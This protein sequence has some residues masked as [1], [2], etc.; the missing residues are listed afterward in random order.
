MSYISETLS[1]PVKYDCDV[2]VAGGGVA[3]VAAALAAARKGASVILLERGFMLGGLATAGIVTI[4]LPIC[5][6]MGNQVTFGLADELLRLSIEYGAEDRYPEAWLNGGS[7]EERRDGKRFEVQFNAQLFAI[8]CER[9]LR[10]AGVRILY[11]ALAVGTSVSEGRITHILIEGKSGREAIEVHRSVVD[12][13]GD[14]DICKLAGAGCVQ[15]GQGNVLAAW[16]YSFG[17]GSFD[18]NMC[19]FCDVPKEDMAPGQSI[20]MLVNRRFVGLETEELSEMMQ[21]SHTAIMNSI[22]EKRKEIP[23]LVPTTIGTI[24]QIRMTKRIKGLTTMDTSHDHHSFPDSVGTFSNWRKRGPI[25][26]LPLSALY[27]EDVR[28]L[29]TAG[30]CISSTDSMWDIT[31]VIPV[32]AVSGEA[33][34]VAAAMT[35]D[36]PSIDISLLQEYLRSQGVKIHID[37]LGLN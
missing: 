29:I 26:E 17:N 11:G 9:V 32:C 12:A 21:L 5:D 36:I 31:R 20:P 1:T 16:Y 4:Y 15:F 8:S 33:A 24:P 19:G 25:Y 13:T 14:A 23:D 6:G 27:G 28:N 7:L 35:N 37:E 2:C 10:E 22:K 30:R 18:L 34:G 3:G